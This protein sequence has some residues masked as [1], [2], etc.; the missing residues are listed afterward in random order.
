MN[1][2]VSIQPKDDDQIYRQVDC[3]Y[4]Y[5]LAVSSLTG[6]GTYR[7]YANIGGANVMNAPGVFDLR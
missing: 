1:E 4:I 2:A 5:N 6:P 7:V 3:K